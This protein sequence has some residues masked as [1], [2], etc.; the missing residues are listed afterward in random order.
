MGEPPWENDDDEKRI[1]LCINNL[2]IEK[3]KKRSISNIIQKNRS[4]TYKDIGWRPILSRLNVF[5]KTTIH[6]ERLSNQ[7]LILS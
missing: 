6:F 7:V 3:T 4:L 1:K 2:P 5:N